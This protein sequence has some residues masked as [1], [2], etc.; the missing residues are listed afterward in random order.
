MY[1]YKVKTILIFV[2]LAINIFLLVTMIVSVNNSITVSDETIDNTIEILKDN[3]IVL[4]CEVPTRIYNLPMIEME[5]LEKDPDIF[6]S[7]ILGEDFTANHSEDYYEYLSPKGKLT[8]NNSKFIYIS[9]LPVNEI[10][11]DLNNQ[12]AEGYAKKI[13]DGFGLDTT[14]LVLKEVKEK[15]ESFEVTFNQNFMG[16]DIYDTS[17][18]LSLNKDKTIKI[19]GYWMIPGKKR[20]NIDN[21]PHHSITSILI[22]FIKNEDRPRDEKTVITDIILA[23]H[24]VPMED[25]KEIQAIPVWIIETENGKQYYY[26]A[27]N[28]KYIVEDLWFT[29]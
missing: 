16:R 13:L 14:Y 1:W 12:T 22:D 9:T 21:F 24:V 18:T 27:R 23:Y 11:D 26:D 6:A 3:G 17:I 2:F 19:T 20:T 25:I 8:I 7:K 28:G 4:D 29:E 15:D 5:N 10:A